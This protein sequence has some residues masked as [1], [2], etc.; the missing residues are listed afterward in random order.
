MTYSDPPSKT[1]LYD[2]M[3][4]LAKS[5]NEKKMP[6]AIIVGDYPVYLLLLELKSENAV[7][8]SK[9]L[10]FM[11]PFHIQMSFIYAIY[12][13]FKGSGISDVLVA[14]GVIAGGSVD[15][16]LR[17]K[18]FK[19]GVR[20]LS[21][22]YETLV[23][24]AL[25]KRLEGT[26][27]SDEVK[28]SIAQLR[29]QTGAKAEELA[30]AYT[31]LES[32]AELKH[33][34][35]TLF[36]EYQDAPQA[37]YW[38]S[39]MEMVE[40][41]TENIHAIRTRNWAEF[42]SSLKLMLP[43]MVAYDNTKYGRHLPDFSAVLEDLPDEQASFMQSGFFAQSMTGKPY[44]SLALDIWI[45]STMNKGSKL[46][47]GWMAILNNEKQLLSNTRNVNNINRV[48]ASV[49]RHA[50]MKKQQREK[51]ADASS[52]Q[53][54]K[55]EKAVQDIS[56][57]FTEFDCDPFDHTNQTLRSLQSGIQ[58]SEKLADDLESAKVDGQNKVKDFMEESV[59]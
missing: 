32:N 31:K 20:C 14:A 54:K 26:T 9:I 16:A 21:L 47:S 45:E 27:L 42:K 15:Q 48:R 24:H 51:H 10:P 8:F 59:F 29:Q 34:V 55:D 13:R 41:L 12:K 52:S 1:I 38:I 11:G 58:A 35:D 53:M 43:W 56:A 3:C 36:E 18:H 22:F 25:N 49:H 2:V 7:Q 28:A 46:K 37:K 23:H 19:R 39:F 5:I 33:L 44:S 57:C 40:V 17:G 30:E 50:D 4:K 6:F